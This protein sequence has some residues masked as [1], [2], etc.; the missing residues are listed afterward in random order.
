MSAKTDTPGDASGSAPSNASGDG[1]G[2]ASAGGE[3]V[4]LDALRWRRRLV[5]V[6]AGTPSALDA[7]E[8]LVAERACG[9]AERDTDVYRA[10]ARSVVPLSRDA[11]ALDEAARATLL[12]KLDGADGDV[13]LV[14]IGKDGGVKERADDL[15]A[16]DAFLDAIDAMPMRRAE[17]A[18]DADDCPTGGPA[19]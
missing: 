8:R 18:R 19:R 16:L 17:M 15:A 10:S 7:L 2:R 12:E 5:L 14:L 1:A 9:L 4:S 3:G 11:V 13:E 6:R